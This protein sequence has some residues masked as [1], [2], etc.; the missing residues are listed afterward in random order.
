MGQITTPSQSVSQA[1][2]RGLR[3]GRLG[4]FELKSGHRG[5]AFFTNEIVLKG[6]RPLVGVDNRPY[7]VVAHRRDRMLDAELSRDA[8]RGFREGH[9][10][11]D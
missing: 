9:A 10:R 6:E 2:I 4:A 8:E 7:G 11:T 5:F 1:A 3:R